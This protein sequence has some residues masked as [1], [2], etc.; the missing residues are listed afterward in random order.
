VI[1]LD[2]EL[3]TGKTA[4]V[5]GLAAGLEIEDAVTSPT[6]TLMHSYPGRLELFHF[7]A[8]MEGREAAFLDGGGSEWFTSGGVAVVEWASRVARFLPE[9]RLELELSHQGQ[10]LFDED[11]QLDPAQ[12]R[13]IRLRATGPST[14]ALLDALRPEIRGYA[15]FRV[16][17]ESS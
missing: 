14:E 12:E 15:G 9:D 10:L 13:G 17:K 3:G 5:R 1:G 7:D 11:G 16:P 2:G 4:L 6:Y 8:W